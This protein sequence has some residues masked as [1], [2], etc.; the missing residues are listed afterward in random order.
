MTKSSN[1]STSISAAKTTPFAVLTL[2]P[3]L[4]EAFRQDLETYERGKNMP[5]ISS[6]ERMG[7]ARG[8]VEGK[9]E[10]I[11]LLLAQQVGAISAETTEKLK[12]LPIEQLDRLAL[13]LRGFT[14]IDDL[15]SWLRQKNSSDT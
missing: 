10:L 4:E 15:T 7:E 12:T 5:Y 9:V 11:G 6:I 1:A 14:S 8:K 3:E 13:D 2:P